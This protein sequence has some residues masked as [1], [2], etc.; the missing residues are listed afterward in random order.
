MGLM[1]ACGVLLAVGLI[2]AWRWS[3]REFRPPAD[4]EGRRDVVRLFLWHVTVAVAAGGAARAPRR[5][6]GGRGRRAP[7]DAL[8]GGHVAG[9]R[10]RPYHRGR[11]GRRRDHR[12]RHDRLLGVHRAVLRPDHPPGL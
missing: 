7:R 8:A 2:A 6:A 5:R 12:R 10:T 9:G 3:G 4:E 1:T 11:R